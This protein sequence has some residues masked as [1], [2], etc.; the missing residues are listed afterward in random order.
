MAISHI[1]V[2]AFEAKV[3]CDD[4][5]RIYIDG[6][7]VA[8][9]QSYRDRWISEITDDAQLVAVDCENF[10]YGDPGGLLAWFG[11]GVASDSTWRCS[12]QGTAAAAAA[13]WYDLDFDDSGWSR[14]YEV[15]NNPSTTTERYWSED[16]N[17]PS[18]AKWIWR[19]ADFKVEEHS[20][21]RRWLNN[22]EK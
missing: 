2:G 6:V 15:Q 11:N 22:G 1:H 12:G 4:S 5:A 3:R 19:D 17:F 8:T 21:C 16:E 13:V 7:L 20:Y 18:S 10:S 14:A 9:T